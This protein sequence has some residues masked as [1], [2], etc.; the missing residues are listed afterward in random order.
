MLQLGTKS[1]SVDGWTVFTDHADN[2]LLWC[3]PGEVTLAVDPITNQPKFTLI[4]YKPAAVAGGAKGGGFLMFEVNLKMRDET[5]Q[6]IL[7]EGSRFTSGA[8]ELAMVPF[9]QGTVR[10][11]ALN[12]QGSGGTEATPAP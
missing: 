6:N 4:K 1:F 11:V 10:C 8:P 3:L 2:K 9:D 5:H 7:S 12:L